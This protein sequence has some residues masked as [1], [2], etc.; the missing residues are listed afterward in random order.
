M[1]IEVLQTNASKIHLPT[2]K[3]RKIHFNNLKKSKIVIISRAINLRAG[4]IEKLVI[5][6]WLIPIVKGSYCVYKFKLSSLSARSRGLKR[7]RSVKWVSFDIENFIRYM[8][9]SYESSFY[10]FLRNAEK[11]WQTVC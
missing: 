2:E 1:D 5:A 7:G 3:I 4:Y 6:T 11:C 9:Y 10:L 8:D